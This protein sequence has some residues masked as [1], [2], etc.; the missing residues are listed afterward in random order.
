MSNHIGEYF[1]SEGEKALEQEYTALIRQ[2]IPY[3]NELPEVHQSKFVRRT[4]HFRSIKEFFYVGMQ[5]IP[6][7]LLEATRS[8]S[9]KNCGDYILHIL[10]YNCLDIY[11]L[12]HLIFLNYLLI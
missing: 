5:A 8:A 10:L 9:V 1:F 7:G 2:Y 11:V 6:E 3:F 4:I 12:L